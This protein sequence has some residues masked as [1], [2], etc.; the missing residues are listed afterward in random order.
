MLTQATAQTT[1]RGPMMG[2]S[3]WNTYGVK[4]TDQLMRQQAEVMAH[5]GYKEAGY[6][7]V[8][9]DDGHFGGRDS[10]TNKMRPHPTRFPNG[11]RPLVD[12]IHSLGLKAGIYSDAGIN[13]CGSQWSKDSI[14][15]GCG[16]WLHHDIDAD[17]Y[18]VDND[19]D[20]IKLDF[21]GGFQLQ[22]IDPS[23]SDR[24]LYER[25]FDMLDQ[26][27]L[28]VGK[29]IRR[30]VC[31]ASYPGTWADKRADSWRT[32]GDIYC[33]W[34]SV[35]N[36]IKQNLY[37]SAFS[38]AGHF[39]D[40]DM[41]EVGRGLSD[42]EDNTHFAMWCMLNSPLMIGCD[43]ATIN[44]T[45]KK[46]LTN[47]DLIAI[48]QDTLYRQAY[49]VDEKD[50][51]YM[52]VRDIEK[53]EDTRRA[54]AVYNPTDSDRVYTVCFEKLDLSG[55]T[56]VRS[57][58]IGDKVDGAYKGGFSVKVPAHGTRVYRLDA[59]KRMERTLYEAETAYLSQYHEYGKQNAYM[60][61]ADVCSGGMKVGYLG[62]RPE[63]DLVWHNV[64]SKRG[65]RY[66]C[67]IDYLT[68]GTRQV[69]I[70]INGKEGDT[71]HLTAPSGNDLMSFSFEAELQPGNNSIR[72]YN[73]G[74]EYCPDIDCMR[75]EPIK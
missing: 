44:A 4:I 43:M 51:V 40:M 16:L 62:N 11:L 8:N 57:L 30:N 19:F 3:S 49:V 26:V 34:K 13:T 65:G 22:K 72:L 70:D 28:K 56:K 20:F 15:L 2:W 31:R 21:C 48:N 74:N 14:S 63:N 58:T 73:K 42:E 35:C 50:G 17:Y 9:I 39:N 46:L 75:I 68:V 52:L 1:K 18:F 33:A 6:R 41:L 12:Y 7:Y 23:V 32:T 64:Y 25:A 10:L 45:T 37:M 66:K 55:K 29:Y 38:S 69:S 54:V 59:K 36:I 67:T 60:Q 71:Y 24:M 5:E 27:G 47:T 61:S 53:P